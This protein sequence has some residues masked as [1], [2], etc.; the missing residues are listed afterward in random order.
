MK[1][2]SGVVAL[3]SPKL[4]DAILE[5][6]PEIAPTGV[7]NAAGETPEK[8]VAPGSIISIFGANLAPHE[9]V[10]LSSP[11]AQTIVGV[12]VEVNGSLLPLI[13]A[14]P[15]RVNAQLPFDLPPGEH[16]LYLKSGA[17]QTAVTFE[18]KR[19]APGLFGTPAG[20][21]AIGLFLRADG[22]AVTTDNPASPGETLTLLGTGFGPLEPNAPSGFA[23]STSQGFRLADP[24]R[25]S[26]GDVELENIVAGPSALGA[27]LTSVQFDV[28]VGAPESGMV[29]VTVTVGETV[30]NTVMLPVREA[31]Q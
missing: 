17:K 31:E 1:D 22:S 5:A 4:L 30:S 2:G 29:S 19:N 11:L 9:E 18:C 13:S 8:A 16:R 24:I 12:T 26:A 3:D 20:D 23:V 28:P 15:E 14:S 21:V 27:G 25:M 6:V 10:G 7:R